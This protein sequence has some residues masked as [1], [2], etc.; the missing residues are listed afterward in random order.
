MDRNATPDVGS[1]TMNFSPSKSTRIYVLKEQLEQAKEII[2]ENCAKVNHNFD[3]LSQLR[4]VRS[5]FYHKDTYLLLRSSS[6][7]TNQHNLKPYTIWTIANY[8]TTS[9]DD[10]S[11]KTAST[12]FQFIAKSVITGT[13]LTRTDIE[14]LHKQCKKGFIKNIFYDIMSDCIVD[15]CI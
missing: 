2:D 12:L 11:A 7:Y 14:D 1:S 6:P 3:I 9:K 15:D 4:Q 10:L 13:A 8:D 5:K